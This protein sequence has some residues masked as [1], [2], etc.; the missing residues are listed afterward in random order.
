MVVVNRIIGK[1]LGKFG[2]KLTRKQKNFDVSSYGNSGHIISGGKTFYLELKAAFPH[3]TVE[4]YREGLKVSLKGIHHYITSSEELYILHEIYVENCYNIISEETLTVIDIGMNVGLSSLYFANMENVTEVHGFEPVKPTF[5]QA[6]VSFSLN[7]EISSKIKPN[8]YG[9]G[10]STRTEEFTYNPDFKGSVGKVDAH[11]KLK[12]L[13][14]TQIE[15]SIKEASKELES[16]IKSEHNNKLL[17]KMDCEG[18]EYEIMDNL[19][20]NAMLSK[21]DI[22]I[23]EWHIK[24]PE[25]LVNQLTKAGFVVH[26]KPVVATLGLIYAFKLN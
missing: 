9:L 5:D 19:F 17:L 14:N 26:K 24:T 16:I 23:L 15:V 1:L 22:I 2:Y 25:N 12:P 8:N 13:E 10:H 11:F 6:L 21:I 20:T 4:N 7:T 3:I 18:G